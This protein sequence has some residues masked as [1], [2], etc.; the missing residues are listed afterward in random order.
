M[1]RRSRPRL[2]EGGADRIS[3]L[4]NVRAGRSAPRFWQ[5]ECRSGAS[6]SAA[7]PGAAKLQRRYFSFKYRV[8]PNG[9][10]VARA[11]SKIINSAIAPKKSASRWASSP[12][13]CKVQSKQGTVAQSGD[14]MAVKDGPA[15]PF[16]EMESCV[17]A[18]RSFWKQITRRFLPKQN[19]FRD[20]QLA[21]PLQNNGRQDS[22]RGPAS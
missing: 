9:P 4:P 2:P 20:T 10:S 17:P 21:I 8:M 1:L 6:T 14:M 11:R 13:T 12:P 22:G 18:L 15:K 16:A 19:P 3:D 5:A 7:R